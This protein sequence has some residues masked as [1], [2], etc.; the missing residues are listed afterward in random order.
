[1]NSPFESPSMNRGNAIHIVLAIPELTCELFSNLT[2][3]E[4][5]NCIRVCRYWMHHL[6]PV[7][8]TNFCNGGRRRTK[9]L[10]ETTAALIRNLPYI[11]TIELTLQDHA[12]L[13]ELAHSTTHASQPGDS[14]SDRGEPCTQLRR[15]TL[16]NSYR[17][18][19]YLGYMKPECINA[20]DFSLLLSNTITLLNR[21]P[22]LTHLTLPFPDVKPDDPILA[23]ISNLKGLQY[24]AVQSN[25]VSPIHT[26]S[27]SLLLRACLPLPEVTEL[28]INSHVRWVDRVHDMDI[29]DM[30][31]II[32]EAAVTRFSQ[33]P[34]PGKI[35]ALELPSRPE[36][37]SNPIALSLLKSGLL[38]LE[39]FTLPQFAGDSLHNNFEQLVR[40]SCPNLKHL[41]C[42]CS[43]GHLD[44]C[45]H[46]RDFIRG[47]SGLLSFVAD[48]FSDEDYDY[49]NNSYQPRCLI[50]D[51][52]SHHRETLEVYELK[53]YDQV[54]SR[55]LQ[56]VLAQ[57]K[58]LKRFHVIAKFPNYYRL[59]GDRGFETEDATE[60]DWV[61]TE[62]RELWITL[63][64]YSIPKYVQ[65]RLYEQI[66][67]LEQLE[68]L[69]LDINRRK[70]PQLYHWG[71]EKRLELDVNM[72]GELAG[73]KN[74]RSLRMASCFCSNMRMPEVEFMHE[75][76]LRLS[77]I[78]LMGLDVSHLRAKEHW[79]WL[80]GKR[81]HLR[82]HTIE[83]GQMPEYVHYL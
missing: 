50:S 34:T 43:S 78:T 45:R 15:L 9:L 75:H 28:R 69:T 22:L 53:N 82:F 76:W 48:A 13:Q 73:L 33:T 36:S 27:V 57:C 30:E 25:G 42:S 35:K 3:H 7:L 83:I 80:I 70:D 77:E 8:W 55:D 2:S 6:E 66:G 39:S 54:A 10:P 4:L 74:L 59:D 61:C 20:R 23:A 44:G 12:V 47:C 18:E 58:R 38:D 19:E 60:G 46:M 37:S 51:L 52:V 41:R 32:E 1:M 40:E 81:P 21:N 26:R 29:P 63:G 65:D 62:L 68:Q 79:Q 56:Q 72:L 71:D 67:R 14:A 5:A 64:R 17:F 11:R 49:R 31:T 24:L 16:E